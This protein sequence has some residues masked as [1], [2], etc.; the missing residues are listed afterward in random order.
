M[1]RIDLAAGGT[2]GPIKHPYGDFQRP[3]RQ[4]ASAIASKHCIAGLVD[5]LMDIT[6]SAKPRV[7]SIKNLA[8]VDNVGVLAFRCTT[9]EGLTCRLTAKRPDQAYFNQ[10][11]PDAVAA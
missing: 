3:A 8:P 5:Q 11:V 2:C 1:C 4:A 9:A 10:P 7:P 6:R